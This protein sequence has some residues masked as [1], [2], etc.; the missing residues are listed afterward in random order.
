MTAKIEDSRRRK[1][2]TGT[3]AASAAGAVWHKPLVNSIVLPAHAQMSIVQLSETISSFEDNDD[4]PDGLY[5]I[6]DGDQTLSLQVFA[7][8]ETLP[9]TNGDGIIVLDLDRVRDDDCNGPVLDTEREDSTVGD[10]NWDV[11]GPVDNNLPAGTYVYTGT[12]TN[13]PNAGAQFEFVIDISFSNIVT[14]D[15][16]DDCDSNPLIVAADM[17]ATVTVRSL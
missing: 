1:I 8:C 2:L 14:D 6:F 15:G 9:P 10:T 4:S 16:L 13:A 17:T 12:R 7:C 11:T 5:V 3:L